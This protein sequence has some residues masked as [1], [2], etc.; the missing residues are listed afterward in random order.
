[1]I[2][3]GELWRIAG[4]HST[5]ARSRVECVT[6]DEAIQLAKQEHKSNGHWQCDSVK[7]SLMDR[8]WSPGLDASIIKG[9]TGC[10]ICK[11]FGGT[12]LHSLLNPITRWHPFELLVGDYLSLL[13]GKG[14]Y[15]MVRLYLDTFSQH[16]SAL[17]TRQWGVQ[18][19]QLT[20]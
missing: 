7:K 20:A 3:D 16:V 19:R 18:K 6:R 5:R 1:M 4:G 2:K 8:I 9:I 11:N 17:N 12:F 14:G 10:G 13:A 15:H